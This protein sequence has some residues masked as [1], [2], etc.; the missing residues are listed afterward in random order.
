[1]PV[2]FKRL[3]LLLS[4]A[5]IAGAQGSKAPKDAAAFK[6][7]EAASFAAHQTNEKITIGVDPYASGDKVKAA[8]GKLD[9]YEFG[10]LPV[11]VVIQNDSD[12]SIRL[13]R[14]KVEYSGPNHNRVDATP[15][16]D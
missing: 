13:D 7:G 10:V 12:K 15:A 4:I 6:V 11:M 5:A 1:M 14:I 16:R 8:F 2:V 9:P 3:A